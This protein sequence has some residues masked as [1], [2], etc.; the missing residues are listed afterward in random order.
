MKRCFP[1]LIVSGYFWAGA[2]FQGYFYGIS[3]LTANIILIIGFIIT[4]LLT[5]EIKVHRFHLILFLFAAI[6]WISLLYAADFEQAL[7]EASKVSILVYLSLFIMMLDRKGMESVYK[8]FIWIGSFLTV[9]GILFDMFRNNRLESTM[10]YANSLAIF[11]L[12]CLSLSM[13]FYLS[14][15]KKIYLLF[16]SIN[17]LGVLLTF[18]RSVWILWLLVLIVLVCIYPQIRKRAQLTYIA[19]AHITGVVLAFVIRKDQFAFW[20][21]VKSI[22]PQTS[23]LQYRFLNWHD[24]LNMLRD[25]WLTGSGGGGWSLLMHLYRSQD[26]YVKYVHNHLLQL[27]LDVGIIGLFLFGCLI[28]MFYY[29]SATSKYVAEQ[30]ALWNSGGMVITALLILHAGF[31]FDFSFPFIFGTFICIMTSAFRNDNAENVGYRIKIR[32]QWGYVAFGVSCTLI[33]LFIWLCVGY[34]NKERGMQLIEGKEW[35]LAQ[36]HFTQAESI[37]PWANTVYYES[38]KGYVILGNETQ[39]ID[40]Y[41]AAEEQ[42]QS[43]LKFVPEN[44]L[45]RELLNDVEKTLHNK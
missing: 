11:L 34:Y 14:T 21:R 13:L 29:Q 1:F 32:S 7:L 30:D 40:M 28:A 42:L 39:K 33:I 19:V 5:N 2:I 9:L 44:D 41:K 20:N 22:Q 15:K 3:Y 4:G 6:Y 23:E 18:S 16:L 43:A 35:A 26:Y 24:S 17:C 10:Q 38:A 12:V 37:I 36:K 31:D 45:Y 27:L 25:Y 8:H